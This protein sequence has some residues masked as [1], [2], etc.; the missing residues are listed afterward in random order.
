MSTHLLGCLNLTPGQKTCFMISMALVS[1]R[2]TTFW[3]QSSSI[4][5]S[6]RHLVDGF[7]P[8]EKMMEFVN[9]VGMTS[10]EMENNPVMFETTNQI[11]NNIIAI[12]IETSTAVWNHQPAMVFPRAPIREKPQP[13]DRAPL[14]RLCSRMASFRVKKNTRRAGE[15]WTEEP[16]FCALILRL[17]LD[18]WFLTFWPCKCTSRSCWWAIFHR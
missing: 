17:N 8:S 2:S 13:L 16:V 15:F 9:G 12:T 7:N 3:P 18:V 10:H 4:K 5:N 1:T 11:Y 6:V 14:S